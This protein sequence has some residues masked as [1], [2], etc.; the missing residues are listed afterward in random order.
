M[1]WYE[2]SCGTSSELPQLSIASCD[3]PAGT[4]AL[5]VSPASIEANDVSTSAEMRKRIVSGRV[6]HVLPSKSPPHA[7]FLTS[8]ISW[9]LRAVSIV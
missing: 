8:T 5:I 6:S 9:S 7:S 2:L 1:K 3:R 4:V